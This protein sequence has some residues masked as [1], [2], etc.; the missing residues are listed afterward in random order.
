M[1]FTVRDE[2]T[3][4]QKLMDKKNGR[5]PFENGC[6]CGEVVR[7]EY[8][9]WHYDEDANKFVQD[10]LKVFGNAG[11]DYLEDQPKLRLLFTIT[12]K[13]AERAYNRRKYRYNKEFGIL[14]YFENYERWYLY[15]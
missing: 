8:V 9:P 13:D 3:R 12:E 7:L 5:L 1:G 14:E 6:A 2:Y 10:E 15:D 4:L 11:F